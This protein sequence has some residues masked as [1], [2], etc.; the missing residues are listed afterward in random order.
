LSFNNPYT[1]EPYDDDANRDHH[2]Q[3]ITLVDIALFEPLPPSWSK[4]QLS[5]YTGGGRFVLSAPLPLSSYPRSLIP[6][7]GEIALWR[8][9]IMWNRGTPLPPRKATVEYVESQLVR[10]NVPVKIAALLNTSRY[11]VRN[12]LVE[13]MYKPLGQG[14]ILLA[15]DSA[16]SFSPA[17][18]QGIHSSIAYLIRL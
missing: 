16:H 12:A 7:E 14:H 1:G 6:G 9:G 18:A 5:F 10:D 3:I 17:G 2:P 8:V 4:D 11:R 13:T 15:G